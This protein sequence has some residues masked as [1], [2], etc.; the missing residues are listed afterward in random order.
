MLT[1]RFNDASELHISDDGFTTSVIKIDDIKTNA[2]T[3]TTVDSALMNLQSWFKDVTKTSVM[4][5][6]SSEGVVMT[7]MNGYT[8]LRA[9]EVDLNGDDEVYNIT[10]AQPTDLEG[11]KSSMQNI[12]NDMTNTNTETSRKVQ[13]LSETINSTKTDFGSKFLSVNEDIENIKNQIA[14]PNPENMELGDLKEYRVAESKINLAAWLA[15]HPIRST[16]H[17]GVMGT[18]SVTAEKQTLLQSAIMIAQMKKAAEDSEY[19]I[20]WNETGKEC[21]YDWTLEQLTTLALE[22]STYVRPYV[23]AQ[24]TKEIE[25]MSAETVEAVNDVDLTYNDVHTSVLHL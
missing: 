7:T 6:L 20:S 4:K 17:K 24:Q 2:I 3:F 21:E 12:L 14:P 10:M 25:I 8:S 19:Q 23:S 16:A 11:M 5:V 1:L 22:I 13:D 15:D 9:I 18:Y